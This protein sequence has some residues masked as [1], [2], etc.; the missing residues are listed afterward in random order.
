MLELE[1]VG[2]EGVPGQA[3]EGGEEPFGY[4]GAVDAGGCGCG[5]W[6]AF[7]HEGGGGVGDGQCAGGG[8]DCRQRT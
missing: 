5:W 8:C 4:W 6:L 2:E 7:D 1:V 3:E